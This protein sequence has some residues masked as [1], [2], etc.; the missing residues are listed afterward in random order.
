MITTVD[1]ASEKIHNL[2]RTLL[3]HTLFTK[4]E[5][6]IISFPTIPVDQ[7]MP[8]RRPYRP[9]RRPQGVQPNMP[10]APEDY[11]RDRQCILCGDFLYDAMGVWRAHYRARE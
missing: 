7:I 10:R 2:F 11:N 1:Y 8:R 3:S 5:E 4:Q 6:T 9:Y